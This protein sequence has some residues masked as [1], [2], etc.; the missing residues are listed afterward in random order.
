MLQ[1][2]QPLVLKLITSHWS[3]SHLMP[4]CGLSIFGHFHITSEP[5][6]KPGAPCSR[7]LNPAGT[8]KPVESRVSSTDGASVQKLAMPPSRGRHVQLQRSKLQRAR[9]ATI[10]E[11]WTGSPKDISR[12]KSLSKVSAKGWHEGRILA[13]SLRRAQKIAHKM[14]RMLPSAGSEGCLGDKN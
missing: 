9:V 1:K 3:L 11:D 8:S 14:S 13:I 10:W 2:S 6:E 7:R 4:M 12:K 5:Q